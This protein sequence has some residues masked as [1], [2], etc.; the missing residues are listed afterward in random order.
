MRARRPHRHA[1]H[2]D[3][4]LL[5]STS[6]STGSPKLVRLTWR[7]IE[8]SARQINQALRNTERDCGMVSA[9][10]FNAYG[11]SVV[12]THLQVGG[13]FVLTSAVVSIW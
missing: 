12:H 1:I 11:Q 13:S 4:T 5:L 10:I 3:L 8:A 6:G 7:N 9:P 2:P